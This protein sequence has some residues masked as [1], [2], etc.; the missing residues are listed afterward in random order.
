MTISFDR[1]VD[2]VSGVGGSA[3][4]ER[5]ELKGRCFTKNTLV[6]TNTVISFS[7]AEEVGEYF[8]FDSEEYKR[9]VFYFAFVSKNITKAESIDFASWNSVAT[10]PLIFGDRL[11]KDLANFTGISD[12]AFNITLGATSVDVT[13]MDFTSDASLGDVAAT[14]E[15][16]IQ[17]ADAA[18]VFTACVVA[19]DAVRGSFNFTGGDV[20]DFVI[21]TA[22]PGSG[23]DIRAI[24]G[25]E[26]K[27]TVNAVD[28]IFSF[29]AVGKMPEQAF[30]DS[31]TANDNFGSFLFMDA[32]TQDEVVAVATAN[33]TQ[34]VKFIFNYGVT[35]ANAATIQAAVSTLQGTDLTLVDK[36]NYPDE[37]DE[38]ATMIVLAATNY[39]ARNSVQ[40]YMFQMFPGLTAKVSDNSLADT[41][42]AINVNYYGVTQQAGRN[43]SF[44]QRGFLQG[45]QNDPVN[46]NIY[47]NEMWFK[48]A[49]GVDLMDLLLSL[50]RLPA[51]TTGETQVVT[52]L[53]DGVIEDALFN[54]TISADKELDPTQQA[55][56]TS[57]T[58]DDSAWY[59]VQDSGY[60]L[61]ANVEPNGANEF[62][63]AYLIVYSKDDVVRK[64]EGTHTLI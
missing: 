56:I 35:A 19:Y 1:Y 20:G 31:F 24:T 7:S 36:I 18:T 27:N 50:S 42:D 53:R 45:G 64:I 2:I 59:Q 28:A 23:T 32:L 25:W 10:A 5:R 39:D 38:M 6:P 62:K 40:N 33:A 55:F 48:D 4:V 44:Y 52:I 26:D 46:T 61:D 13:G 37:F 54:G 63:I 58:G 30:T 34:N 12:G 3:D 17:A 22:A 11:P 8:G 47:A 41:Y 51:N 60:W 9:A 43:I 49:A 14:I 16:A 15:A 21:T 29:G 57:I